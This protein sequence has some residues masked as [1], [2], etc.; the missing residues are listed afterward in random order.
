MVIL[1]STY[2]A[3]VARAETAEA[4]N[5]R[6]RALNERQQVLVHQA[7]DERDESDSENE[8]L[9]AIL[10]VVASC[11]ENDDVAFGKHL[12]VEQVRVEVAHHTE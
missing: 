8:R 6:L 9:R 3:L 2:D 5:E 1:G 7:R 10:N 4:E 12:C 11:S